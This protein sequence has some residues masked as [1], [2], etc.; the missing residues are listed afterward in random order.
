MAIYLDHAASTPVHPDA[1]AAM[2][3][4]HCDPLLMANP[5]STHASGREVKARLNDF[6]ARVARR[7][8]CEPASVIFN[9]GGTEGDNH[10]L[11]GMLGSDPSGKH[12][13]ISA[14]EHEAVWEMAHHLQRRG[15]KLSIAPV[16]EH[17]ETDLEFVEDL[18]LSERP[19]AVSV[20]AV[21]NETGVVQP[22]RELAAI[23]SENQIPFHSDC[24]RV[25]GHGLEEIITDGNIYLLNG[26]AH[27]FGGPRGCGVL[28]DR[29]RMLP[30]YSFGGG[31]EHGLRSGTENLAGIAGLTLALELA[32]REHAVKVE[33]LRKYLETQIMRRLPASVIHGSGAIRATHITSVAFPGHTAAFMQP[34]LSERGCFVGTGSACH[35]GAAKGSRVL[36]A[37]GVPLEL[38]M[39]TLRISLGWNTKLIELDA[40]LTHLEACLQAEHSL[41]GSA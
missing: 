17:G 33:T 16:N 36:R 34:W 4:I 22:V 20:M 14:I 13:L 2:H 31:H 6:R 23:C 35:E 18:L 38:D 27:K 32:D 28:I 40:F 1:A 21:N 30:P 7:F 19:D 5:S 26:T 3:E 39:A 8:E 41:A 12:L 10:A 15:L 24:V 9:S 25:V 11:L 29:R 37:M